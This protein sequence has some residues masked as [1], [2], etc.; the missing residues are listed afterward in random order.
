ME[1][2]INYIIVFQSLPNGEEET[3]REIY[4]DCIKRRI[5]LYNKHIIHRFY[6]ISDKCEFYSI[7]NNI[8][9]T[10][11]FFSGNLLF[12]FEMHGNKDSGIYFK[13]NSYIEWRRVADI[14]RDVNVLTGNRLYVTFATCYGR[15]FYAEPDLH[16]KIPCHGCIS[17]S[18]EVST[19]EILED[20]SSI[21]EC[22]IDKGNIIQALECVNSK[23]KFIYKDMESHI[24]S[25]FDDFINNLIK[26]GDEGGCYD[27]L[28]K[29]L[30]EK[31]GEDM[32]ELDIKN[33]L[34]E[35]L[36]RNTLFNK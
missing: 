12:H 27:L 17:S 5:N 9:K 4:E 7:I 28:K 8:K 18:K 13:D 10:I 34:R 6:D 26:R 3:G 24:I 1:G 11:D 30:G 21:F 29:K 23:T 16:K 20:F 33:H 2:D 25:A 19:S 22:M 15:Y 32:A 14:L 31:I 36:Y 35:K